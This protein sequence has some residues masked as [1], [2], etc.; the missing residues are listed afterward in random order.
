MT[1]DEWN[2]KDYQ[3][4]RPKSRGCPSVLLAVGAVLVA[5]LRLA[6]GRK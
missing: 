1:E 3:D 2:A 6:R 4:S 5:M